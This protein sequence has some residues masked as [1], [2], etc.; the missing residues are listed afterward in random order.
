MKD[1]QLSPVSKEDVLLLKLPFYTNE[2]YKINNY[3]VGKDNNVIGSIS[4]NTT[5]DKKNNKVLYIRGIEII[6][7]HRN[8]GYASTLVKEL[9]KTALDNKFHHVR[10]EAA[11]NSKS[12]WEKHN[13]HEINEF[14][15]D[16]PIMITELV[17][18]L[19]S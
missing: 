13:F 4:Y 6:D 11:F 15:D 8:K 18:T 17:K 10:V 2:G 1:L 12:F 7:K 19:N 14:N 16:N 3:W 5:T 9:I